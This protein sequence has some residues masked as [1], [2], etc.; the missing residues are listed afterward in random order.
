MTNLPLYHSHP[1]QIQN[2]ELYLYPSTKSKVVVNLHFSISIVVNLDLSKG[3]GPNNQLLTL[4]ENKRQNE[5]RSLVTC[6]CDLMT[7]ITVFILFIL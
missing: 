5:R 2:R 7:I 1:P 6:D 3:A 4:K